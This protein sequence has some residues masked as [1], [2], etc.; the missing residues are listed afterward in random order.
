MM[1]QGSETCCGKGSD[2]FVTVCPA[3][4]SDIK[5]SSE[6]EIW[7]NVAICPG[8][9]LASCSLVASGHTLIPRLKD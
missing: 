8:L 5:G 3:H 9:V 2:C 6:I 1:S 7:I 4:A